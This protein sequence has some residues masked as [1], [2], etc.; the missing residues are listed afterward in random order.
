MRDYAARYPENLAGLVFVD[1]STPLQQDNPAFKAAAKGP[2]QWVGMLLMKSVYAVGIPR[3]MGQCS[4]S[5]KGFETHAGKLLA[6]DIC[7]AQAGAVAAEED[8]MNQSGQE[9]IH[10]GPYGALPI[11]IFSHDPAKFLPKQN[12]PK[13]MVDVSNAW[14]QM[15][16][17]LKNL[18]TRSRRIVAKG[19]SHYVQIDR[20]DLIEKEVPLFIEQIRG[21]VPQP[22]DYGSTITE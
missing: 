7:H 16:E 18:S 15:Q 5:T 20:A 11:L 6:E 22:T 8:S 19:S 2:P 13:W 10:T 12:P 3:L 21:T 1:G 9:T 14:S 4:R 17:D